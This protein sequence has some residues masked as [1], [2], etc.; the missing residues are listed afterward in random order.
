LEF[1]RQNVLKLDTG[2]SVRI[3]PHGLA[4][5]MNLVMSIGNLC[6][7]TENPRPNRHLLGFE[8]E[9]ASQLEEAG[10]FCCLVSFCSICKQYRSAIVGRRLNADRLEFVQKFVFPPS[11]TELLPVRESKKERAAYDAQTDGLKIPPM[12]TDFED[13]EGGS[14]LAIA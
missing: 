13:P 7:A 4:G 8:Q 10:R 1:S 5:H 14:S 2:P 3:C 6:A 12:P 11:H 9:S